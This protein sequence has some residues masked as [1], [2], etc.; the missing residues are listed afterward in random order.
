MEHQSLCSAS[1]IPHSMHT[2]IRGFGGSLFP[3]KRFNRDMCPPGPRSIS[4]VTLDGPGGFP[5]VSVSGTRPL[6]IVGGLSPVFPRKARK[7]RKARKEDQIF[8]FVAFVVSCFSWSCFSWFVV[9][10]C[11]Q[12]G[13]GTSA[14]G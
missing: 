2:R 5:V 8:F 11:D 1:G 13:D 7:A 3:N 10:A 9:V 12:R 6:R 14:W 4:N